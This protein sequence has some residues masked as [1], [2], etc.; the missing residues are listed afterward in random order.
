[1][2]WE[3]YV[4]RGGREALS[5]AQAAV[6][7]QTFGILSGNPNDLLLAESFHGTIIA[8]TR[9]AGIFQVKSLL[10]DAISSDRDLSTAWRSWSQAEEAM[11]VVL[12]LYIH[13]SE[14]A[15]IFHHEPLLRHN[16]QRLP[17]CC[18]DELF[19][20]PSAERWHDLVKTQNLGASAPEEPPYQALMRSYAILA[21]RVAAIIEARCG[22]LDDDA[23][24]EH[25]NLLM[26]WH[27]AHISTAG[28]GM[29]DPSCLMIL[30]HEAF[31]HLYVDFD[32]LERVLGREGLTASQDDVKALH[33]WVPQ[34][35]GQR[36]A[37][38]AMLIYRRLETLPINTELALHVPK[39][40]FYSG[41]VI[42][43]HV[44]FR[45]TGTAYADVDI[46]E[47]RSSDRWRSAS[48]VSLPSPSVLLSQLDAS[49]LYNV[50][51]LLR[52]QGHW[53]VSR[54]FA[55]ILDT[56]IETLVDAAASFE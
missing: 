8:W 38:H 30:W 23:I 52:R 26:S 19:S 25:G 35:E 27:A 16:P 32:L 9:Q 11:R 34:A 44:K 1:V 13:D 49:A 53:E 47:L 15:S 28:Q 22:H 5:V 41:L 36:C 51:D 43:C 40:L 45:S 12:A 6:L 17:Q 10:Q 54:R 37:V 50:A 42:Y 18:S 14:F 55:S 3:A 46:P 7:G 24:K 39:A 20:A 2:Q 4:F 21:G 29:R 33:N 31:M 48:P 56:L